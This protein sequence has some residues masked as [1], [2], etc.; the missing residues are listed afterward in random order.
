MEYTGLSLTTT[1]SQDIV[2]KRGADY[3]P[4]SSLCS[5][6]IPVRMAIP[7]LG[8]AI[9]GPWCGMDRVRGGYVK[10]TRGNSART[11]LTSTKTLKIPVG[12]WTLFP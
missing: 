4:P 7:F 2:V 8:W 6:R 11:P 9:V 12:V 10:W 3:P 1:Q 5:A